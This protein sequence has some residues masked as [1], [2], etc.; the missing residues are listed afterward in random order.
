MSNRTIYWIVG[1]IF[2]V[3]LVVMLASW[4]YNRANAEANRKAQELFAAYRKAG[5]RTPANRKQVARV[6]GKDGG[7]VCKFAGSK[8]Q[9]AYLKTRLGVGGE[10]YYRPVR[11]DREVLQGLVLIVQVY[12]PGKL[13]DV[14]DLV[15][16][17]H[18]A[19]VIRR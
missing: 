14:R 2:G 7:A 6:L 4:R 19:D 12:C 8:I 17:L 11:V 3:L 13:D 9:K 1:A 10:F 5:L 18:Y 15:K 16:S